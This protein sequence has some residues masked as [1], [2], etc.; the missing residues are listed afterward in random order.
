MMVMMT[1]RRQT[2]ESR[3]REKNTQGSCERKLISSRCLTTNCTH[4]LSETDHASAT[5]VNLG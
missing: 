1:S 4:K 2:F 3:I 5:A